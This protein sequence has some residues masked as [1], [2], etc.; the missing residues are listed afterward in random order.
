MIIYSWRGLSDFSIQD[1]GE[2]GVEEKKE[3]VIREESEH[4]TSFKMDKERKNSFND[5]DRKENGMHSGVKVESFSA[6]AGN[7]YSQQKQ[8]HGVQGNSLREEN[9]QS[10]GNV[11]GYLS[12]FYSHYSNQYINTINLHNYHGKL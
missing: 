6:R 9:G 5:R 2:S 3:G 7:V 4:V 10:L 11:F 1:Y 12:L 8:N